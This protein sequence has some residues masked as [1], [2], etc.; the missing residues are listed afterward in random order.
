M[1][2][3]ITSKQDIT[4]K[5]G[6]KFVVYKGILQDGATVEAFLTA[7]QAEQFAIPEGAIAT[8]EQ[9]KKVF[10]ELPVC[11]IEFNQRGQVQTLKA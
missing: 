8:R 6:D 5:K 11:E 4:S 9:M 1:E 7:Q 10:Q 3:V 2:I